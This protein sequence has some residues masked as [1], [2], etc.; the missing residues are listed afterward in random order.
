L[1]GTT[2]QEKELSRARMGVRWVCGASRKFKN[3]NGNTLPIKSPKFSQGCF[4]NLKGCGKA[5]PNN[6]THAS[7]CEEIS[8]NS[9]IWGTIK[10]KRMSGS[11]AVS[12]FMI[13][14]DEISSEKNLMAKVLEAMEKKLNIDMGKA[15]MGF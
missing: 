4:G 8:I 5:S 9:D 10:S 15:V 11:P 13:A 14:N 12:I 2:N 6:G 7:K 3:S 1:K